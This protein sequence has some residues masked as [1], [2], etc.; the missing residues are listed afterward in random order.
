MAQRYHNPRAHER[1]AQGLCPE[2]GEKAEQH[3][4]SPNFWERPLSGCLLL[5]QGVRDRIQQYL[6]DT[7]KEQ[8]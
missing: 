6:E 3:D 5:P 8:Q 4:S 7:K 1:M 2:C